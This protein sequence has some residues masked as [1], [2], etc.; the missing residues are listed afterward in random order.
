MQLSKKYIPLWL[1]FAIVIALVALNR[2]HSFFWDT[3]Q[4]ASKHATFFYSNHFSELLL[5]NDI[6]SG[7]IPAF[8]F[9]IALV[10]RLFGRT[11]E[12]SHLAM[13]PF[14]VGIVWQI[15]ALCRK[16]IP[17]KY[18]GIAA[19]MVVI[20]PSLLSQIILVSPD[21]M[22]IF[23]FL[24]GTNAVLGNR[25]LLLCLSILLLFLTSMRGMMVSVCLLCLDVYCNVRLKSEKHAL[26]KQLL[27]RSLLYLPS[28]LV[29]VSFN[30]FH[31]L[32]KGWI[33]YHKDSPW[34][35]CF[36]PVEGFRGFLF[37]V[38]IY[39]W[40]ILDFGRI[41]IWFV[42]LMLILRYRKKVFAS[43]RI[44]PL[45][46]LLICVL[47]ILPLNMLWAKNLT[48]HRYLIPIYVIVAIFCAAILFSDYVNTKLRSALFIVWVILLVSGNF[49]IYPTRI[50]QGWDATLAHLPY[51]NL[52]KNAIS[53]LEKQRI[54]FKQVQSFFPNVATLD[55]IDLSGDQRNFKN[56][57]GKTEYI[58]FSNVFNVPDKDQNFITKHFTVVKRFEDRGVFI[59]IYKKR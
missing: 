47:L 24:M 40:R 21:V 29:F 48:A 43:Q 34:A 58:F 8:G 32:K 12:A 6:D 20:D 4:L 35:K 11:L 45:A 55:E 57:D 54:D 1:G 31:Y 22:L 16:F 59:S 53:Y 19:L 14:A 17:Q 15:S 52:R 9:Y 56:F 49:W 7:H 33:G 25:K 18:A 13:L 23:F 2:H 26:F 46:L 38:G 36:E 37:N 10:W 28:L 5:P 50:S 42:L 3:V 51:Y 30:T 27:S 44:R 41:G 39:G